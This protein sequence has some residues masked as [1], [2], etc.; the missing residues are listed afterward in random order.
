[1]PYFDGVPQPAAGRTS[2]L[3]AGAPMD[4]VLNLAVARCAGRGRA[5]AVPELRDAAGQ[6]VRVDHVREYHLR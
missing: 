5:C 6:A 3:P 1:M 2:P 4:V